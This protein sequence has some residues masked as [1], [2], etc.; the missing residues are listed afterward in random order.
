M[1]HGKNGPPYRLDL[2]QKA[3]AIEKTARREAEKQAAMASAGVVYLQSLLAAVVQQAGGTVVISP[4]DLEPFA[5]SEPLATVKIE[6]N[7]IRLIAAPIAVK[8]TEAPEKLH[9]KLRGGDVDLVAHPRPTTPTAVGLCQN[10]G[11]ESALFPA[12]EKQSGQVRQICTEC[13]L[14]Q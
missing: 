2:V 5:H 10:C 14:L 9:G 11:H 12:P 1:G 3:I 7:S 8:A 4:E 13:L 6:G